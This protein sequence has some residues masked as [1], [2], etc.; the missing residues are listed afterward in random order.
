MLR[1]AAQERQAVQ[2]R[3]CALDTLASGSQA[4]L[5]GTDSFGSISSGGMWLSPQLAASRGP[6]Q[7]ALVPSP[8]A[9]AEMRGTVL[10]TGGLG[11]IGLLVGLWVAAS[12]P[13][14]SVLLLS[15]TGR[16]NALPEAAANA[17]APITA[18]RCDV[19]SADELH[20]LVNELGAA[21][22]P[23]VEAIFHSGGI[24]QVCESIFT[25]RRV[26]L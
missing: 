12:W 20:S 17:A 26:M 13:A 24:L 25:P 23:P 2:W 8:A 21:G 11:D 9:A 18:V 7:S 14:A 4:A 19:S 22:A 6:A 5:H 1:V 15:R 10:V 3:S 16:A